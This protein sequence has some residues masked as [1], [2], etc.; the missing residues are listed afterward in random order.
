MCYQNTGAPDVTQSI[1]HAIKMLTNTYSCSERH[2]QTQYETKGIADSQGKT[3]TSMYFC[4]SQLSSHTF[5]VPISF[6]ASIL[7]YAFTDIL[8]SS[9]AQNMCKNKTVHNIVISTT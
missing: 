9:S 7:R 3:V 5:L 8:D 2:T 4:R 6:L 1:I